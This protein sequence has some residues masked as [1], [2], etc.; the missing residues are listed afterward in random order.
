MVHLAM[1]SHRRQ[2]KNIHLDADRFLATHHKVSRK[3]E[4]EF[5]DHDEGL[6]DRLD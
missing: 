6:Y 2:T 1:A 4:P 3:Q 5:L